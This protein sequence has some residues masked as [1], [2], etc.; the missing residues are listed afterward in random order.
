[1]DALADKIVDDISNLAGTIPTPSIP[2]FGNPLQVLQLLTCP[3]TPLALVEDPDLLNEVDPNILRAK[4]SRIIRYQCQYVTANYEAHVDSLQSADIINMFRG[5]L[6]D[7]Y[8]VLLNPTDFVISFALSSAYSLIV[9]SIC[10]DTFDDETYPFK[11]FDE[12]RSS[13]SFDGLVPGGMPSNAT[14]VCS[15]LAVPELKLQDWQ[16]LTINL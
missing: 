2:D 11:A 4:F 14:A 12:A 7:V 6:K 8:R 1:L 16:R 5:F 9:Q 13:F 15:T 3:L 10:P